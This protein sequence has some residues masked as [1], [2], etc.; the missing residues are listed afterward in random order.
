MSAQEGPQK[1][2]FE[3][4][5]GLGRVLGPRWPQ[6]P[7]R[8]LPR[9]IFLYF[10][11][12][13]GGFWKPTWCILGPNLAAT[14]CVQR[15][16]GLLAQPWIYMYMYMDI[17]LFLSLYIYIYPRLRQQ[18]ATAL[19]ARSSSQVGSQ[20]PSSWAPKSTKLGSK[21]KKNQSWEGSGEVLGP[22]WPPRASQDQNIPQNQKFS[23][24]L[25]HPFWR[26]KPSQN[27]FFR[28]PRG[29]NFLVHFLIASRSIFL[30]FQVQLATQNPPKIEPRWVPRGIPRANCPNH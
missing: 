22:S 13:L 24:P 25:G 29:V 2:V 19:D 9:L 5:F 6:D 27:Q 12:Q 3:V 7:S 16:G 1:L 20:N 30:G 11:A 17:S 8:D 15:C 4:H 23:P 18:P 14:A 28:V 10:G 26:P 21:I